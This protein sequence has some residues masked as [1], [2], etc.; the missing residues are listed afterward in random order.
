MEK[1]GWKTLTAVALMV[2]VALAEGVLGIDVPGVT[3]ADN[4]VTLLIEALGLG[5]LRA[6]MAKQ[7]IGGL[8]KK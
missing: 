4:W 8:L 7:I 1:Y 6:A 2:V 5:G 3:V